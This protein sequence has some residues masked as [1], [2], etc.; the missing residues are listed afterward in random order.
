MPYRYVEHTADAAFE[1][2]GG[3]L[4][5]VFTAAAEATL[6][7][8]VEKPET[9]APRLGHDLEL[10]AESEEVLLH[11]FLEELVFLEDARGLLLRVAQIEV[12]RRDG[13]W[14]LRARLSG[15][16]A[17]PARHALLADVKAVTW[18]GFRLARDG[19][20][21]RAWVLLDV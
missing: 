1:A 16:R 18:H 14:R 12:T 6:G 15:E 20:R 19:D 2:T 9:I 10:E 3:S 5:Q 21:W 8:I 11:R 4:E 7:V 13:A 17:D